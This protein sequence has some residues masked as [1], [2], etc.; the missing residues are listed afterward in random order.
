MGKGY[1]KQY[2]RKYEGSPTRSLEDNLPGLTKLFPLS[3]QGYFGVKGNGRHVRRIFSEDAL[4]TAKVFF[5]LL[6]RGAGDARP[7]SRTGIVV[8]LKDGTRVT[9]R[10]ISTSDGSPAVDI[11]VSR[12]IGQIAT[13]QKIH[14]EKED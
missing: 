1:A 14:F 5:R 2:K 7:I 11:N 6:T 9:Y 8:T 12:R 10:E 3:P 13:F 4:R